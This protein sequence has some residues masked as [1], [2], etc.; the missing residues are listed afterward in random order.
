L[1][2]FRKS[3]LLKIVLGGITHFEKKLWG[4]LIGKDYFPNVKKMIWYAGK[5]MKYFTLKI[6]LHT[7]SK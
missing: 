7:G 5:R 6:E 1:L 4:L 2:F 3:S